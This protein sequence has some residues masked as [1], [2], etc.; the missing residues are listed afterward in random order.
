MEEKK[1]SVTLLRFN[2]MLN[3]NKLEKELKGEP[4]R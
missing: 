1:E 2:Q 3:E 4:G